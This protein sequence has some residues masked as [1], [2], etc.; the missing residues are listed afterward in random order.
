MSSAPIKSFVLKGNIND[1]IK[2]KLYPFSEFQQGRWN[3]S[4]SQLIFHLTN[5][6]KI[7]EKVIS[8]K[9]IC[10]LSC[11]FIKATQ[12]SKNNEI[13]TIFQNLNIF[14]LQGLKNEKKI[15]NFEKKWSL[16]NNLS[17]E[18]KLNVTNLAETD[19][20]KM[21]KADFYVMVLLQRIE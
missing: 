15:V 9:E 8:V 2:I 4:I 17:E 18:L 19:I 11:N 10:G 7:E 3:I 6:V 14:I 13:E 21:I 16:I 12:Y 20:F 5:E 1:G